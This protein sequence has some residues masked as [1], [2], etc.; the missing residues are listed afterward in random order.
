M[1]QEQV[2]EKLIMLKDDIP[3]FAVIFSGKT[4]KKV[5]GT[6][7]PAKH[8]IIIHNNNFKNE[9]SLMYTAIHEFAHHVHHS[10][11]PLPISS[12]SHTTK[13]WSIFHNLLFKAENLA[14]YENIFEKNEEFIKLTERIKIDYISKNG[15]LI[16][17]FG[18]VLIEAQK[19]CQDYNV[20]FTDYIDRVLRIP[21]DSAKS[22]I[23]SE[24]FNIIPEIGY[25]NMKSLVSIN[26]PEKRQLAQD[27][28]LQGKTVDMVKQEFK[29]KKVSEDE[30][31][32][33]MNEKS[34]IENR[35]QN[36][37]EKLKIIEN[38]LRDAEW[39]SLQIN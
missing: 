18:K 4:S 12:K 11:S 14:I 30:I 6:Y 22:I 1:N 10:T 17:E 27:A 34:S 24:M 2:K 23:K 39:T 7:H 19:L 35:I 16:R 3:D 36:L 15:N 13:F 37:K 25:D 8:E 26:D 21:R 29:S 31:E 20:S 38:K 5:N 9:N 33:L 32:V 28:F